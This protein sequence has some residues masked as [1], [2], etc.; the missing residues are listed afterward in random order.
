[1]RRTRWAAK[2]LL[3]RALK[4]PTELRAKKVKNVRTTAMGDTVGQL[5]MQRQDWSTMQTRK[6]RALHAHKAVR[7]LAAKGG[8]DDGMGTAASAE[9]L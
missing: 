2:D 3:K 4:Q 1:M 7:V 8:L 6:V 9:G 5:H